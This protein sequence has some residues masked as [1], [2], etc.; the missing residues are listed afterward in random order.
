LY[1]TSVD[2][3]TFARV[4]LPPLKRFGTDATGNLDRFIFPTTSDGFALVGEYDPQ[5]LYATTDGAT[6]W[7][8]VTLGSGVSILGLSAT[9]TSVVAVTAR[10]SRL[11]RGCHDYAIAQSPLDALHWHTSALPRA[12]TVQ[13]Y[14]EFDPNPAVYGSRLWL[15]E[16]PPNAAV[17]FY[18]ANAGATFQKLTGNVLISVAGCALSAM[19]ATD[20]WAQCPTGMQVSFAYSNNAGASW[21]H[22]PQQQFF[23]TGGGRFDPVSSNLAYLAYGM[24]QPLVRITDGGTK[25]S[26][27][28]TLACSKSDSSIAALSFTGEDRG[29]AICDAG[30]GA[31]DGE[32]L[33]TSDGGATWRHVAAN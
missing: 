12:S 11:G 19:S 15:S 28:G 5:T 10:C 23:G 7:H 27:V 26:S 8:K 2:A 16:Q 33:R 6:T 9:S 24:N 4:N 29:L 20:L 18:S 30:F 25:V 13:G 32:L 1:R 22:V 21:H 17:V 31:K 14:L 3:T